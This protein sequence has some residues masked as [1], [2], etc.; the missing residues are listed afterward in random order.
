MILRCLGP[1]A[2][3]VLSLA[4]ATIL[5]AS[6]SHSSSAQE[7]SNEFWPE[8]DLSLRV[9]PVFRMIVHA[10]ISNNSDSKY[11]EG[12]IGPGFDFKLTKS[13]SF[14][15]TYF[16]IASLSHVDDP[17]NEERLMFDGT[18]RFPLAGGFRIGDRNR[19]ELREL[20]PDWSHRYRNRL[21]LERPIERKRELLP[22][23]SAEY[24][25]DSR[26]DRWNRRRFTLGCEADLGHDSSLDFNIVRQIDPENPTTH[27]TAL[28]ITWTIGLA[29]KRGHDSE[30]DILKRVSD[31]RVDVAPARLRLL[32]SQI[33]GA[34]AVS[35]LT[36]EHRREE[37]S[38]PEIPLVDRGVEPFGV[39][40][41][42]AQIRI[43]VRS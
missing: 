11:A 10:G 41:D 13:L 33:E 30:S 38:I 22:Y 23:F 15:T 34:D 35:Y 1:R 8:V 3:E 9:S 21:R 40:L 29:L 17:H 26:Y 31:E 20:G 16:H 36:A 6:V 43:D 19:V 2:R 12:T 14:R 7:N 27:L 4:L 24:S 18:I 25:Y 28:G 32:H 39:H 5:T 37:E 42:R